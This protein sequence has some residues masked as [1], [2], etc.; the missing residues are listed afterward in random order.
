MFFIL[1]V[2][3]VLF[4][5]RKSELNIQTL[6]SQFKFIYYEKCLLNATLFVVSKTQTKEDRFGMLQE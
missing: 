1:L 5:T 2:I 4:K 3:R 6:A